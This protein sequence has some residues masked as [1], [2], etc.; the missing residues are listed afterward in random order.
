MVI[1]RLFTQTAG[2]GKIVKCHKRKKVQPPI[3]HSFA[4]GVY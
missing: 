2:R 1:T 4:V 3:R